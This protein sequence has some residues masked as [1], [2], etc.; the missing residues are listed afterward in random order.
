MLSKAPRIIYIKFPCPIYDFSFSFKSNFRKKSTHHAKIKLIA[1]QLIKIR[2]I[3]WKCCPNK[4]IQLISLKRMKSERN[5][6]LINI[7]LTFINKGLFKNYL[8]K[9]FDFH[10]P[11]RQNCRSQNQPPP[12]LLKRYVISEQ[13]F[14]ILSC[15]KKKSFNS[16]NKTWMINHV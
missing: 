15:C 13:P 16:F 4:H 9:N 10:L 6:S 1:Q 5:C 11:W 7:K 2:N 3:V 8:A 14:T 12:L